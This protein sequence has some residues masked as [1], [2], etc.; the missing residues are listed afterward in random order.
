MTSSNRSKQTYYTLDTIERSAYKN[1]HVIL[2]DDSTV[3]PI[4]PVHLDKYSF[5]IDFI[6]IIRSNKIW[7]NPCVNYNIGFKFVRGGKVII[8]NAE[9]CHV[10]DVISYVVSN[11]HDNHYHVFDV[12]A[13]SSYASNEIIYSLDTSKTTVYINEKLFDVWYQSKSNNRKY[14]F[15]TA[16]TLSTFQK[17]G[18]FSY[19]YSLGSSYDDDDL[20]LRIISKFITIQ[21]LHHT[22]INCGGI[23]L[24]HTRNDTPTS[25]GWDTGKESNET[26]LNKK[27][28][29]LNK[30]KIYMEVSENIDTFSDNYNK[31]ASV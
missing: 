17:I 20:V 8:Q 6:E 16:C 14:H 29:Y 15:L 9:V 24:Y 25:G 31:L 22:V 26:L 1:I 12:A 13:S 28:N 2:V 5:S 11:I 21:P 23:H 4:D 3:D 19:D 7:H 30:Y 18:G 27:K 10:G